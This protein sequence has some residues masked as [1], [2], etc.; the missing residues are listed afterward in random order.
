LTIGKM[1][2]QT[3]Q[4]RAGELPYTLVFIDNWEDGDADESMEGWGAAIYAS[5]HSQLTIDNWEDG[6]ADESM[7]GWG[8]AI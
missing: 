4:W 3:N 1:A 6:D 7:E 2:M 5:F 8:V